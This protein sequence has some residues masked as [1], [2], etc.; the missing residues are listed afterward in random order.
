MM[1]RTGA[2]LRRWNIL[3][4]ILK[5]FNRKK[6]KE[7]KTHTTAGKSY[8]N[9]VVLR[10]VEEFDRC[11]GNLARNSDVKIQEIKSFSEI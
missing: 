6:L 7:H 11:F 1:K 4:K 5:V 9:R 10:S 2:I 8:K 3:R